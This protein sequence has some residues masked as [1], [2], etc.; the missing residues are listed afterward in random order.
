MDHSRALRFSGRYF[1][2]TTLAGL[3][4]LIAVAAGGYL[5]AT[6]I[7]LGPAG[8][9]GIPLPVV[10]SQ[11]Y[12]GL[13]PIVLGVAIWR[14]GKAWALYTTLTGAMAEE[15]EDTYDTEHVKSD[16]VAVLDD[17][18]ADMQQD[19]QSV[20][21]EVRDLKADEE[22]EFGGPESGTETN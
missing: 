8:M 4:G 1:L 14:L 21:R 19:L 6:G 10:S 22:F 3:L 2:Y 13:V 9:N 15:L 7:S 18:L 5:I 12:L 16:I 11:A 20:N 17:R